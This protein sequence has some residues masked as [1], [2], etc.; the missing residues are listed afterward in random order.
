MPKPT[1]P[2]YNKSMKL[3]V[4]TLRS[5]ELAGFK[6]FAKR[7]KIDF[8]GGLIA[9][10]GPNG[11]GKSNIADAIRWVFGE[12]K[13]KSLRTEKS[14][15]LIYNG[16]EGKP[17]ASMAEVVI[18]LDNSS[19][20][21]PID[22]GEIEITRRL[23]RSG[24]SNYLLNGKK[25]SLNSI[26]ELLIK[27]GFGVGSYTVIGQ[28]MIDR[29]ILSTGKERKQLF[30][31]ASGIKQFEIQQNQTTKRIESIMQ[32]LAQTA[33]IISEIQPQHDTLLSQ[34]NLLKKRNQ[35]SEDLLI[36][37]RG[38][39]VQNNSSLQTQKSLLNGQLSKNLRAQKA[40]QTDLA[41][42]EKEHATN[43]GRTGSHPSIKITRDLG[44][45]ET[46]HNQ[47]EQTT[48]K[49]I[50]QAE[51]LDS[52]I[53]A[54]DPAV[55][56]TQEEI[57]LLHLTLDMHDKTQKL[58]EAVVD[59]LSK[60]VS[61]VDAKI[62]VQAAALEV[63]R[64]SLLKSQKTQYLNHSLGLVDI[65]R[66][67]VKSNKTIADL[68]II[69]YKLR[70][71]IKHSIADNSMEL[72]LRVGKVQNIISGFL[73]EREKIVD[74][75]TSEVIRLRA[76]ELDSATTKQKISELNAKLQ[77]IGKANERGKLKT[78]KLQIT[79]SLEQQE[80][81]KKALHTKIMSLRQ[82]LVGLAN[83]SVDASYNNYYKKH[84]AFSNRSIELAQEA[85]NLRLS[86]DEINT[87]IAA[88]DKLK[89][90]WAI[91]NITAAQVDTKKLINYDYISRLEAE[92]GLLAEISPE[93]S[94][95]AQRASERLGYLI[96][97]KL[98]LEKTIINL[99]KVSKGTNDKMQKVFE[100][101]FYRINNNFARIFKDLF[102]G[103][104]ASLELKQQD[105]E[106]GVEIMVQLP[107]KRAQNIS[108]LSGG[109]KAL[110]SVALLA[111]ILAA[112]PS[113]FIVLDEVD[114]ALD[115]QNTKKFAQVLTTITKHSQVLVVT[116]NHETMSVASELLGVTTSNNN[117]SHIIR[118]QLDSLPVGSK[119]K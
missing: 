40:L 86:L 30:E 92:V 74:S 75:Q 50:F 29:L 73:D 24:E 5:I 51:Q 42:L 66:D 18:T 108:S 107:S 95:D 91:K 13:N 69:F 55:N 4:A 94:S 16:G 34:A 79:A 60:K 37:R 118:V 88:N 3:K 28:G 23:Y 59:R 77:Q 20:A 21:L 44:E 61:G 2:K 33:D 116:H 83:N 22:L 41:Q 10:V 25:V 62:E 110:A 49:L 11:S 89:N 109:E 63:I 105:N 56:A 64:K 102:G 85:T 35:L 104:S 98:D 90:K 45:L 14:E 54:V 82:E 76:I 38:Y 57:A 53:I 6:S 70:R 72:A 46:H 71:M 113:P 93:V 87:Q 58:I 99:Q 52:Q 78:Q 8:G 119:S 96:N 106:Y 67:G 65:L 111:G 114:A 81:Q 39:I 7:V 36:H 32:N 112:N 1:S 117:D 27:S 84:E 47:L 43:S 26:Q 15:D 19:G 48:S 97:Q 17:R 100:Q 101:G 103:G 68:D 9:I 31:E 12:Q 80:K 115:E